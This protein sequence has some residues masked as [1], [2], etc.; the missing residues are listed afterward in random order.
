MA[1]GSVSARSATVL[2]SPACLCQRGVG[3]LVPFFAGAG[4]SRGAAGAGPLMTADGAASVGLSEVSE[5]S[6]LPPLCFCA[7]SL[8]PP[9][10]LSFSLL[11]ARGVGNITSSSS[12]FP[13][14]FLS[15]HVFL[16]GSQS[17]EP[18]SLPRSK[19]RASGS[20]GSLLLGSQSEQAASLRVS[21]KTRRLVLLGSQREHVASLS[22]SPRAWPEGTGG[23]M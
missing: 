22:V 16:L 4:L 10:Y 19:W 6:P 11:L 17:G 3:P 23:S 20:P 9:H 21:R 15:H 14:V 8:S 18:P 1:G 5:S 12:C 7:L 13:F 2:R